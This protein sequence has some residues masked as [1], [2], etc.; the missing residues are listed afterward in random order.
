[1]GGTGDQH[2]ISPSPGTSQVIPEEETSALRSSCFPSPGPWGQRNAPFP[3][4]TFPKGLLLGWTLPAS[5]HLHSQRTVSLACPEHTGGCGGSGWVQAQQR[6]CS[7]NPCRTPPACPAW[8][9]LLC[10]ACG[11]GRFGQGVPVPRHR[12]GAGRAGSSPRSGLVQ[13]LVTPQPLGGNSPLPP[14]PEFCNHSTNWYH[15]LFIRIYVRATRDSPAA[16]GAG[17]H[18]WPC[19]RVPQASRLGP[20]ESG[21]PGSSS[22]FAPHPRSGCAVVEPWQVMEPGG[23]FC[24]PALGSCTAPQE[25]PCTPAQPSPHSSGMN[26]F[27][28][29]KRPGSA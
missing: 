19:S 20:A 6:G 27:L 23:E 17:R 28:G 3:V 29:C 16:G 11:P 13:S 26:P 15:M 2:R 4:M 14:A 18:V 1:M 8:P 5:P 21:C 25:P 10:P 12:P 7:V 24:P 22:L 9:G